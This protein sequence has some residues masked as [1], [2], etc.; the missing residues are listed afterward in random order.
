MIVGAITGAAAIAGFV[1]FFLAPGITSEAAINISRPPEIVW[2]F[3]AN[4]KN[5]PLWTP[6]FSRVEVLP[7]DRWKAYGRDGSAVLFEDMTVA[8]PK[9]LV[10]KMIE[11][12]N[13]VGGIWELDLLPALGGGC[14]VTAHATLM[15]QNPFQ[16]VM[17]RLLFNGDKEERKTLELL[18]RALESR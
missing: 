18:K 3:L 2:Q 17:A 11:T 8:P 5:L 12:D 16:R 13:S 14:T 10:S 4:H 9:R 6:E 15:M 1:G 7:H